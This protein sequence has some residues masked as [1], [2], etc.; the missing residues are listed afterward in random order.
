MRCLNCHAEYVEADQFCRQCGVELTAPSTSLVSSQ[1]GLPAVLYNPQVPRSVAASVGALALGV[2]IE[3]LRRTLVAR[4]TRPSRAT[5]LP[6]LTDIKDILAPSQS[7]PPRG[8]EVQETVVY[9]RRVIR[10]AN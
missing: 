2:G 8:Y 7:K 10:R 5:T 1:S 9:M 3:L 6:A 4:L